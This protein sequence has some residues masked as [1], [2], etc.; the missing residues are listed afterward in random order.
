[1]NSDCNDSDED[2]L[3][4]ELRL[5]SASH[6]LF[7]SCGVCGGIYY[8]LTLSALPVTLTVAEYIAKNPSDCKYRPVLKITSSLL[9]LVVIIG[10]V[11]RA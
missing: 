7:S 2:S 9:C 6:I 3:A 5:F 1:M 11:G 4:L 8:M 10:G